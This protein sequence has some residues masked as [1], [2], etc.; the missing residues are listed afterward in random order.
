MSDQM[1]K[2]L[3]QFKDLASL[4]KY[5][6]AQYKTILSLTK[7]LKILE[8]ENN[9][10]KDILE[11]TTPVLNEDKKTFS[12]PAVEAASSE[13]MIAKVQLSRLN[14]ISLDRELTLEEAKRVE[15]FSKILTSKGTD[16]PAL[17]QLQKMDSSDLLKALE[18]ES[19]Q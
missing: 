10:L 1:D 4:Q 19:V 8:Q 16:K 7:K 17:I 5:A 11:K 13:E 14:E 6:D 3:E 2:M 12:L 9:D 15:I 18:N